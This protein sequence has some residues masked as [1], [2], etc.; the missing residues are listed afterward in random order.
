VLLFQAK[1]QHVNYK[2]QTSLEAKLEEDLSTI[3]KRK[4][5]ID[6]HIVESQT[7]PSIEATTVKKEGE[8]SCTLSIVCT[9][10]ICM[11]IEFYIY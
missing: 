8:S 1:D 4:G 7:N 10:T 11:I 9:K 6:V 5:S 3:P 2:F